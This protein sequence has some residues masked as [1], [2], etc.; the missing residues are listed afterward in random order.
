M[1]EHKNSQGSS[2]TSRYYVTKLVY[3]EVF[4]DITE[5]IKREKQIKGGSRTKKLQLVK[6]QNPNFGDLYNDIIN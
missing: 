5:A 1:H 3:Y 6:S 2:F 4:A